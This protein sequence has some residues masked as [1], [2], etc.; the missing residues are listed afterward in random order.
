[1]TDLIQRKCDKFVDQFIGDG[2]FSNL[3]FIS[4]WNVFVICNFDICSLC[5]FFLLMYFL[6]FCLIILHLF[7]K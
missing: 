7:A 6:R 3:L 5:V 2:R 4:S 1:M